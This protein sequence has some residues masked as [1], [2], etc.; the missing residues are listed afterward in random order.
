MS[1]F[2]VIRD[3]GPAWTDGKGAFEQPGVDDHAAFMNTLAD[4]GIV[5]FAGPLAGSEHGRI[6]ALLIVNATARPSSTTASRPTRGRK[7][8]GSSPPASSRGTSSSAPTGS[9]PRRRSGLELRP[10]RPASIRPRDPCG[11]TRTSTDVTDVTDDNLL[12]RLHRPQRR[13]ASM[14]MQPRRLPRQRRSAGRSPHRP[15]HGRRLIPRTERP[16]QPM[17]RDRPSR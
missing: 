9:P 16:A 17:R 13:A 10:R 1:Y 14:T 15:N 4:E 5:L 7:H 11:R 8:N 12:L 2:A 3:A 6:R